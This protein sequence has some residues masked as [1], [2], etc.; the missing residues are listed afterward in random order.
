SGLI[1]IAA[2]SASAQSHRL[3]FRSAAT[4]TALLELFTS[5]GCSSCPPAER[6]LTGLK[7]SPRLWEA[8]VPVA[9]HVD[10]WDR[11]GW[12]DR[13]ASKEFS[14]RQR[15]YAASWG[16]ASLYT[17]A[18]CWMAGNGVIRSAQRMDR[19]HPVPVLEF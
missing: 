19:A 5:E 18:L 10:D 14:D 13:W 12:P 6:W 8:F 15:A 7:D 2:L 1:S 17:P 11:L 3:E 4:Q 16:S 9:F